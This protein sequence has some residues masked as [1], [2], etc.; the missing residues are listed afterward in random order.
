MSDDDV[1]MEDS[2]ANESDEELAG[3][4]EELLSAV[5]DKDVEG[6]RDTLKTAPKNCDLREAIFEAVLNKG[7]MSTSHVSHE[8]ITNSNAILRSLRQSASDTI[9]NAWTFLNAVENGDHPQVDTL[10]N[11]ESVDRCTALMLLHDLGNDE[12]NE[13]IERLSTGPLDDVGRCLALRMAAKFGKETLFSQLLSIASPYLN[14]SLVATAAEDEMWHDVSDHVE[15]LLRNAVD[16]GD[17]AAIKQLIKSV[18]SLDIDVRIMVRDA[19]LKK[20]YD[21]A[22]M[23][24]NAQSGPIQNTWPLWNALSN[25][26]QEKID[27]VLKDEGIDASLAV[28]FLAMFGNR[29]ETTIDRFLKSFHKDLNLDLAIGTAGLVCDENDFRLRNKLTGAVDAVSCTNNLIDAARWG[30]KSNVTSLLKKAPPSINFQAVINAANEGKHESIASQVKKHFGTTLWNTVYKGDKN[31]VAEL[32]KYPPADYDFKVAVLV[33]TRNNHDDIREMILNKASEDIRRSWKLWQTGKSGEESDLQQ[34]RELR[35]NLDF[36]HREL[37]LDLAA[38]Y[39]NRAIAEALLEG[40]PPSYHFYSSVNEAVQTGHGGMVNLLT[41]VCRQEIEAAAE[42]GDIEELEKVTATAPRVTDLRAAI[43]KARSKGNQKIVTRLLAAHM[44]MLESEARTGNTTEVLYQLD[45]CHPQNTDFRW[46]VVLASF[47]GMSYTAEKIAENSPGGKKA[48][49]LQQLEKDEDIEAL[50]KDPE[51]DW[52]LALAL[53]VDVPKRNLGLMNKLLERMP[54]DIDLSLALAAAF[55]LENESVCDDLLKRPNAPDRFLALKA[56][57]ISFDKDVSDEVLNKLVNGA[58]SSLDVG[59]VVALARAWTTDYVSTKDKVATK[60]TNSF[61]QEF[62]RVVQSGRRAPISQM[63]RNAPYD[64]D[65]SYALQWAAWNDRDDIIALLLKD[66]PPTLKLESALSVAA[67]AGRKKAVIELLKHPIN[68]MSFAFNEAIKNDHREVTRLLLDRTVRT[69]NF[70]PSLAWAVQNG[71]DKILTILLKSV[72]S[73]TD[74]GLALVAAAST[75]RKEMVIELLKGAPDTLNIMTALGEAIN[76]GHWDIRDHLLQHGLIVAA[77]SGNLDAVTELLQGAPSTTDVTLALNEAIKKN[78]KEIIDKLLGA[79][80][81]AT[82]TEPLELAAQNGLDDVVTLLLKRA[83]P[84]VNREPALIHAASAGRK[85]MVIELLK[86]APEDLS[87]SA[88]LIE[89]IKNNHR[90]I[91]DKLISVAGKSDFAGPLA[92]AV[93]SG[94]GDIVTLLLKNAP[95]TTN[96]E[97]ALINAAKGNRKEIVIE[98]LNDAPSTLDITTALNWATV[99]GYDE[100]ANALLTTTRNVDL[101]QPLAWAASNG[102]DNVV[103]LIL[104]NPPSTLNREPA[105]INAAVA[106][107]KEI[108][109]ELLKDAPSTLN[110]TEALKQACRLGR[111][112][113]ADILLGAKVKLDLA[114]PLAW[115]VLGGNQNAVD[116]LLKKMPDNTQYPWALL[117]A[118]GENRQEMANLILK[119]SSESIKNAWALRDALKDETQNRQF[120]DDLLKKPDIDRALVL[121]WYVE[122]DDSEAVDRLLKEGT[123]RALGIFAAALKGNPVM[124]KK[125]LDGAPQTLNPIESIQYVNQTLRRPN[126]TRPKG[127]FQELLPKLTAHQTIYTLASKRPALIFEAPHG[128][129]GKKVSDEWRKWVQMVMGRFPRVDDEVMPPFS[130]IAK[131][132]I[133]SGLSHEERQLKEAQIEIVSKR[134]ESRDFPINPLTAVISLLPETKMFKQD[135]AAAIARI[136]R[137]IDVMINRENKELQSKPDK[138]GVAREISEERHVELQQEMNL[139][140][141]RALGFCTNLLS[142]GFKDLETI[143]SDVIAEQRYETGEERVDYLMKKLYND[144]SLELAELIAIETRQDGH[145]FP[146]GDQRMPYPNQTPEL[147]SLLDKRLGS[148]YRLNPDEVVIEFDGIAENRAREMK[149]EKYEAKSNAEIGAAMT[150][151]ACSATI[152]N[153]D[154]DN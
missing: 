35:K 103:A 82:F 101:T 149:P 51:L 58:P 124:M 83:P 125:L 30:Q 81:N 60:L 85:E 127:N 87:V 33:A 29:Y 20:D 13:V 91:I 113:I 11:G 93:A 36:K 115:A 138:Q 9:T 6:V 112:E 38:I 136:W 144:M 42:K 4:H 15:R 117:V 100:V 142:N 75:G 55:Y 32:L 46:A 17:R 71:R 123:D 129:K 14:Y 22:L 7:T 59:L 24:V 147:K 70:S 95:S 99:S 141:P 86:N 108:L 74:R 65:R 135:E 37:A 52:P 132:F 89:A 63:L 143:V 102:H 134:Y 40:V 19:L 21:S 76:N 114:T 120:I 57:V 92:A 119:D 107:R 69:F 47:E 109:I 66:A 128:E 145:M 78:H 26:D 68:D 110:A 49:S 1:E 50:L 8:T 12:D 53:S 31:T 111:G 39:D 79:A 97:P 98:L 126:L 139:N 44:D 90:E 25:N 43:D 104:K 130:D 48:L 72:P 45:Q 96:R 106:N 23:L 56:V 146:L 16:F 3:F 150:A 84:T 77:K 137:L 105:L 152:K 88:A 10:L 2:Q 133:P 28:T 18:P 154:G 153:A 64:L 122:K 54:K 80:A 94:R 140:A 5:Q 34:M 151:D 116:Q 27:A 61:T 41:R 131:Q 148:A 121:A 73:S 62:N 118:V 67:S